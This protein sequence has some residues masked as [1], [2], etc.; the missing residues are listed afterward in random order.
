MRS[1]D[2]PSAMPTDAFGFGLFE[3]WLHKMHRA[4]TE[5]NEHGIC[6][7]TECFTTSPFFKKYLNLII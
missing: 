7:R 6:E 1:D 5:T 4:E 2:V 3:K